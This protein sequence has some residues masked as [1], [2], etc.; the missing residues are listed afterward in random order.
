L[1]FSDIRFQTIYRQ[2]DFD[3][4]KCFIYWLDRS[5]VYTEP[6]CKTGIISYH[7]ITV[8]GYGTLNGIDYWV[9][10]KNQK[11]FNNN[12]FIIH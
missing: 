12:P 11:Y 1:I 4:P 5:G 3:W 6:N 2:V 9:N 10:K 7:A 8:V